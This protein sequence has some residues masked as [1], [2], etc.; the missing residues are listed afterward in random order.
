M[1]AAP[2]P[3]KLPSSPALSKFETL[4]L[5]KLWRATIKPR[6]DEAWATAKTKL[7][8]ALQGKPL[9]VIGS[10]V[11][12]IDAYLLNGPK[13]RTSEHTKFLTDAQKFLA[14]LQQTI[15][16]ILAPPK[17]ISDKARKVLVG[18]VTLAGFLGLYQAVKKA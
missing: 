3:P 16:K 9:L 14:N 18:I 8:D 11:G 6:L 5:D 2:Q 4:I 15:D 1:S 7:L 17:P 13:P 10:V 12:A